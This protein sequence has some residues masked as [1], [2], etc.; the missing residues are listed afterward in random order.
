M[1][2]KDLETLADLLAEKLVAR[3][4][5]RVLPPLAQGAQCDDKKNK[6]QYASIK[7]KREVAGGYKSPAQ[8]AR[9][10]QKRLRQKDLQKS[11]Q[12][13]TEDKCETLAQP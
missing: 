2:P 11:L 6:D 12:T 7:T 10:L 3:L 5:P 4:G 8:R 1:T 9:E 13:I